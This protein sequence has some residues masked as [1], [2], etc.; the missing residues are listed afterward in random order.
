[1]MPD[2]SVVNVFVYMPKEGFN[3]VSIKGMHFFLYTNYGI[4]KGYRSGGL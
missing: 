1:M 4:D 2:T 3:R